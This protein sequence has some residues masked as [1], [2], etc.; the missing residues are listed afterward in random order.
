MNK[1]ARFTAEFKAVNSLGLLMR[2]P[3]QAMLLVSLMLLSP[4]S[5]CFGE[6]EVQSLDATSLTVLEAS[7]HGVGASD[8]W[9][10]GEMFMTGLISS[11]T[12]LLVQ[13]VVQMVLWV[14]LTAGLEMQ[15]LLM[16]T[17]LPILK[18]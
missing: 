14:T 18:V 12:I 3:L 15:T 1:F 5:G 11:Q 10:N 4:L 16:N 17:Q 6:D 8:G 2:L 9:V 7:S 13:P